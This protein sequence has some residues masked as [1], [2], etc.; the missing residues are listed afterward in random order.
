MC[1]RDS[2]SIGQGGMEGRNIVL[3]AR[4][5]RAIRLHHQ[6]TSDRL[7]HEGGVGVIN[8]IRRWPSNTW[9]CLHYC[10]AA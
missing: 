1:I 10:I 4:G 7:H 5:R 2:S 9:M 6:Q 8:T 3:S